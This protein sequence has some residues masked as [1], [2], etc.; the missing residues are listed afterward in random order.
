MCETSSNRFIVSLGQAATGPAMK[1]SLCIARTFRAVLGAA[2]ALAEL[3]GWQ[4]S[5]LS[6]A[7]TDASLKM[8]SRS[9]ERTRSANWQPSSVGCGGRVSRHR[10]FLLPRGPDIRE[11][12]PTPSARAPAAV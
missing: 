3:T 8:P 10:G 2:F 9:P 6:N 11:I 5:V 4:A 1:L 7:W 12:G